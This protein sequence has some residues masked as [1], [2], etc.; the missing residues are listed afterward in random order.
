MTPPQRSY[1][2]VVMLLLPQYGALLMAGY[3][4]FIDTA[5]PL[6]IEYQ[7]PKFLSRPVESKVEAVAA[8]IVEAKSGSVVWIWR[9]TCR[10]RPIPGEGRPIWQSGAFFWGGPQRT[11]PAGVV[12]CRGRATEV[13][14]PTTSPTRNFTYLL[15]VNFQVNP[16]TSIDVV[17][18]PVELRVLA[19]EK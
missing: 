14:V 19:L 13:D 11:V 15:T 8:E 4:L 9:E 17:Y 2:T 12:G 5:P 7:H 1:W 18:P 6:I 16:L 10:T 3:W